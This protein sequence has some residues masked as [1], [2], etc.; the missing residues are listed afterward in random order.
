MPE[1]P[2][3]LRVDLHWIL[4]SLKAVNAPEPDA[5][6]LDEFR[7]KRFFF[8]HA[9]KCWAQP[10]FPGFGRKAKRGIEIAW[11]DPCCALV[12]RCT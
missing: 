8:V 10:R 5:M 6:F 11:V 3:A 12:R 2:D 7:R 1:V 4:S 9:V